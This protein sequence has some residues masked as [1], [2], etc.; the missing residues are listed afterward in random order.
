MKTAKLTIGIVSIVLSLVVLFQ[1]CAAGI[2][3]ALANDSKDASGGMGVFVAILLIVAGIVGIA[4]RASKG[5][6]IAATIIYALA[7][8]VGVSSTG[9]FKDLLVWG[10]IALIFAAVFLISVFTQN[11]GKPQVP[12]QS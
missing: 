8:I 9:I 4:A 10:I 7:G 2:G 6:A 3:T 5:G 11:Y 1:S 12:P